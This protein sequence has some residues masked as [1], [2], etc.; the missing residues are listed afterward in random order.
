MSGCLLDYLLFLEG[1]QY[2]TAEP[3]DKGVLAAQEQERRLNLPL[4]P[5]VQQPLYGFLFVKIGG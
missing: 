2:R 1:A 3:F 5:D 4:L